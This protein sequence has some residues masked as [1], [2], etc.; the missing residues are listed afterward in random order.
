MKRTFILL[1]ATSVLFVSCKDKK[2]ASV[3][4][5]KEITATNPAQDSA[6]IKQTI[7][8]FY[9][10]YVANYS[11]FDKYDLYS[12]IKK[13]DTPPYK[14][15]WDVVDKYQ[16]FIR[17]SVP[18]LGDEFLAHQRTIFKKSDSAFKVDVDDE[19]PYYFDYDW[20]TNSQEDP[21]Y[22]LEG[23]NKSKNWM[24]QVN[25]D[26]AVVNI[27]GEPLPSQEKPDTLINLA[28]KK[29]KGKWKIAKIGND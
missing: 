28:L 25:G 5:D 2:T 11:K 9:N 23:I 4:K 26:D 18:Q 10:W 15:N 1:L 19:I 27:I 20:Y 21:A 12:G 3:D 7:T 6:E 22:L 29:E 8:D 17:D 14:I 16:A 13:A 24:M